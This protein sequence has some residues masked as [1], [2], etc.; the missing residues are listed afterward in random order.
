MEYNLTQKQCLN[1]IVDGNI[2]K[3]SYS[4][5]YLLKLSVDA[6]ST[7]SCQKFKEMF[8]YDEKKIEAMINY[9][10][11]SESIDKQK[12]Y[13]FAVIKTIMDMNS[14]LVEIEEETIW[15]KKYANYKHIYSVLGVLFSYNVLPQGK[16]AEKVNISKNAL[17]N[18]FRR[19]NSFGLWQKKQYG[20]NNYYTITAKGKKVF[21]NYNRARI[22]NDKEK[23][24]DYVSYLLTLIG[25]EMQ[26][27][28]PSADYIIHEINCKY[29]GAVLT[30]ISKIR[31]RQLFLKRAIGLKRERLTYDK[32]L[33]DSKFDYDTKSVL[34]WENDYFGYVGEKR[35]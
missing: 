12:I 11:I 35:R 1:E 33:F 25:D 16:I 27:E 14:L 2:E 8:Q 7:D 32:K 34:G 19:T 28:H 6:I 23:N 15:Q 24:Q 17:S 10:Q 22:S 21:E 30:N 26:K 20:R 4:A 5:D 31:L 13:Y 9:L 3:I 29:R 18:F